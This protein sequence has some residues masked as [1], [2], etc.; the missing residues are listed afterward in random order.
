MATTGKP[1][2]LNVPE[3][4][5]PAK[6][7]HFNT[8]A[9]HIDEWYNDLPRAHIGE[10]S[11]HIY[12]ALRETNGTL[13]PN[14]ERFYFLQKITP[15]IEEI[16][17]SL[18]GK[19]THVSATLSMKNIKVAH[20]AREILT[21]LTTGYKI[22]I[23]LI[24]NHGGL[25]TSKSLLL[26]SIYHTLLHM[27]QILTNEYLVY[28]SAPP[29]LWLELHTLYSFAR[30]HNLNTGVVTTRHLRKDKTK[31]IDN[32]YLQTLLLAL[33]NPY[34][35]SQEDTLNIQ[36][37]LKYWAPFCKLS[38]SHAD[39]QAS[40]LFAVNPYKDD[41]PRFH[42]QLDLENEPCL[43]LDTSLLI[44]KIRESSLLSTNQ[45]G[46]LHV[47]EQEEAT[48]ALSKTTLKRLLLSWEL[49]SKRQFPRHKKSSSVEVTIGLSSIHRY[50]SNFSNEND[51]WQRPAVFS[52]KEKTPDPLHGQK[53][54]LWD[55]GQRV[56][57]TA[58]IN[59]DLSPDL[60][61]TT[62]TPAHRYLLKKIDE[63]AGG[64]CLLWE[65]KEHA[66]L[67]VDDLLCVVESPDQPQN[68]TLC[69]IRWMKK[70]DAIVIMGAEVLTPTAEAV[71][72]KLKQESKQ[73]EDFSY[74]LI[75]PTI[76]AINRPETIM[77]SSFFHTGNTVLLHQNNGETLI[78]LS[79]LI[80]SNKWFKQFQYTTTSL[81]KEQNKNNLEE[82]GDFDTIW[83]S[84]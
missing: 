66:P 30:T 78:Q 16:I 44:K 2:M 51:N 69:I 29:L 70:E 49:L 79:R 60:P 18:Q 36:H 67:N 1:L 83:S 35:L 9:K 74:A 3:Q 17:A 4:K 81:N 22:I 10:L 82:S 7:T 19:Y 25:F 56:Q 73:T 54:T 34:Q 77:T 45:A 31:T 32:I 8:Q 38:E 12:H 33:A 47:G 59:D 15:A 14:Q 39:T 20:L 63:S 71:R 57:A 23:D 53:N 48:R 21:E 68:Y 84:L 6:T 24:H 55:F 28:T 75:L 64:Y 80:Q 52:A 61:D 26:P 27:H 72:I 50:I 41:P 40:G 65:Q 37:S 58:T 43:I 5:K 62:C 13:I 76:K 11:R 42:S 46:H